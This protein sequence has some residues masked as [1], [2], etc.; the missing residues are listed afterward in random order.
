MLN[1]LTSLLTFLIVQVNQPF[2]YSHL[3]ITI[4][5]NKSTSPKTS[6]ILEALNI[7]CENLENGFIGKKEEP[8]SESEME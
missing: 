3:Q 6:S 2:F 4:F 8:L 7:A 5:F 1:D